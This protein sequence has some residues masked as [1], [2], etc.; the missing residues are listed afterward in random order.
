V[1]DHAALLADYERHLARSPLRG[2]SPR[3]YASAVK[4][5][6]G[7]LDV[8]DV[9]GKPLEDPAAWGWAVRDYRTHLVTVAKR[10]PSTVNKDVAALDNFAAWKGLGKAEV[11]RQEVPQR[12]PRAL[13]PRG[14]T[15]W[16][17][18][19]EACPGARDRALAL[20]PLYAGA[21]VAEIAR[22]DTDDLSL[23]ARKGQLRLIGKGEKT[24][25]VPVH[26]KLREALAAW[27]AER[28]SWP[29]ADTAPLFLGRQGTRLVTSSIRDVLAGISRK[30]GLEDEVTPHMLRHTFGTTLV[31]DGV[32]L[33][34]VAQLMGHAR[35]ET[36]RVYTQPT[37]A[38]LERAIASLP[39]DE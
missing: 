6:L 3:T 18:A 5:F 15:R 26:A 8:S 38:D 4:G 33:V 2:H 28:P 11:K 31:R 29:G 23:S 9:D 25:T 14:I 34:T 35:L 32:D 30:A 1:T 22:L 19:V 16:L 7:W 20:T 21:R 27:L 12:A 36:T 39:S 17:R 24:R 37:E 10:A 13:E